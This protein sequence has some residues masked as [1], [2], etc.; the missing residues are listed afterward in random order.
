MADE[1]TNEVQETEAKEIPEVKG[2]LTL[3]HR[4]WAQRQ[5]AAT[6]RRA[7]QAMD[8]GEGQIAGSLMQVAQI[9]L[10]VATWPRADTF[11]GGYA[12]RGKEA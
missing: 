4:E 5:A 7:A 11:I 9:L 8:E 12:I 2:R 3:G 6:M 1:T 10:G